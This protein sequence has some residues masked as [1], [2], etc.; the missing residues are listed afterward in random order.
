MTEY[1]HI[2]NHDKGGLDVKF[3]DEF[4]ADICSLFFAGRQTPLPDHTVKHYMYQ[5]CKSLEHMHR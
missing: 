2:D 3:L 4:R 1:K 5:L